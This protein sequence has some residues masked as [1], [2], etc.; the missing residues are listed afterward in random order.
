MKTY[1]P[2]RISK[3]ANIYVFSE[4]GQSL[5]MLWIENNLWRLYRNSG[6]E[7]SPRFSPRYSVCALILI[8]KFFHELSGFNSIADR[9]Q[10]IFVSL[11]IRF[12]STIAAQFLPPKRNLE[13]A[14]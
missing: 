1:F 3:K 7:Q 14:C 9:Y 8:N 10:V 5:S 2:I 6:K 12:R 13:E 4:L 11:S